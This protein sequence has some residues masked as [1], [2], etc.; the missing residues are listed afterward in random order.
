MCDR[1]RQKGNTFWAKSNDLVTTF[2]RKVV[3]RKVSNTNGSCALVT[4]LTTFYLYIK[5]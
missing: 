3:T 1:K 4:T 2:F 5:N